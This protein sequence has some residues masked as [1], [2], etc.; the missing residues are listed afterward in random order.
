MIKLNENKGLTSI[1]FCI[2]DKE[3]VINLLRLQKVLFEYRNIVADFQECVNIWQ[4]YS[5]D[6]CAS[7]LFFPDKD[8]DILK[9][10][11]SSN[12]FTNYFDYGED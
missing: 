11:E 8:E 1:D 9:Q 5:N 10:I 6:L 7:W 4:R 3:D 12:F 2:Y